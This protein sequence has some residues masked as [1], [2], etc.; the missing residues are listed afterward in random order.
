[1]NWQWWQP[2]CLLRRVVVN[3]KGDTD[4]AIAGVL[5]KSRGA[6]LVLRDCTLHRQQQPPAPMDGE[7]VI[8]RDNVAFVQVP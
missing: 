4:T 8:H 3:L 1:L 7:V 6:W 2:P 5:W